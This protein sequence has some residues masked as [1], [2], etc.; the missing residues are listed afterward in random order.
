MSQTR[1]LDRFLE[2]VKIGSQ[3]DF[4]ALT[5]PSSPGQL[6]VGKLLLK[7]L[8]EMGLDESFQDEHGLVHA[9]IPGNPAAPADTNQIAAQQSQIGT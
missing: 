3:A 2:Y 1:L 7:E 9:L 8:H 6:E 5:Y 4:R